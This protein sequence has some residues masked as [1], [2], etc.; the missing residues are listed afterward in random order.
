M[1]EL[2]PEGD[3]F[4]AEKRNQQHNNK[5][6]FRPVWFSVGSWGVFFYPIFYSSFV[7]RRLKQVLAGLI[8]LARCSGR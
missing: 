7:S 1:S 4:F 2:R 3:A 5:V 6:V 8:E